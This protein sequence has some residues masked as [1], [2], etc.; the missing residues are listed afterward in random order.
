MRI[1]KI[2]SQHRRDFTATIECEHCGNE[3]TLFGGYDDTFYHANVVPKIKWSKCGKVAPS[4][5][6]PLSTKYPE[7]EVV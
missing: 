7:S 6:R 1:K 2:L 3:D 5:Y 4:D